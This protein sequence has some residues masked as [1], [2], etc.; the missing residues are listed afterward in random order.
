MGV[1]ESAFLKGSGIETGCVS[2][3]VD[4][5]EFIQFL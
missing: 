2:C 5:Y 4:L 3:D 1:W